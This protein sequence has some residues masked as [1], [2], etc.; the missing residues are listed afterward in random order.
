MMITF[1]YVE[2]SK[3]FGLRRRA[4][5]LEA[6]TMM[7]VWYGPW[8][9]TS[10]AV[11]DDIMAHCFDEFMGLFQEEEVSVYDQDEDDFGF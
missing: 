6:S 8:R 4:E 7:S 10:S 3:W 1:T 2:T 11:R 5:K 9:F